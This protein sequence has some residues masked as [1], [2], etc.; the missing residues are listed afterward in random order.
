MTNVLPVLYDDPVGGVPQ[1]YPRDAI[2]KIERYHDGQTTPTPKRI[3]FTQGELLGSVSG[4]LGSR[5]FV[6]K[7]GHQ[8]VVTSDKDDPESGFERELPHA[9]IV[10]SEAGGDAHPCPR[11]SRRG[12][13]SR[14]SRSRPSS[15]R[16]RCSEWRP[17][18]MS[19]RNASVELRTAP[20]RQVF[21]GR[22]SNGSRRRRTCLFAKGSGG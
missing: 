21:N 2:P 5:G 6:E 10:I 12:L 1:S 19:R 18:G 11:L 4:E 16:R 9:E 14:P 22:L 8:V 3:D 7:R 17:A 13:D 20:E 15:S